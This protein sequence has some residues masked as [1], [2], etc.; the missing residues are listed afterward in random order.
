MKTVKIGAKIRFRKAILDIEGRAVLG[1][2]KAENPSYKD[3]R[4][5]KYIE[6]TLVSKDAESALAEV[7]K[8]AGFLYNPLTETLDLK[9]IE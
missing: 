8:S 5:G 9:V 4:A 1:L 3:C 7:R 2:L 6:L